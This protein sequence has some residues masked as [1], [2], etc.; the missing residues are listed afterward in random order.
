MPHAVAHE[1]HEREQQQRYDA[2]NGR[3]LDD[4][5]TEAEPSV[6]LPRRLPGQQAG[7]P[8]ECRRRDTLG[9]R[10]LGRGIE[11]R[12]GVGSFHFRRQTPRLQSMCQAQSSLLAD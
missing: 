10:R 8:G 12:G 1:G 5:A 7:N 11:G 6:I 4:G 2:H 3:K 9:R